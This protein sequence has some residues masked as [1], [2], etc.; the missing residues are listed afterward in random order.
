MVLPV[1]AFWVALA[2]MLIGVIGVILPGVPGVGLIWLAALVYAV[3]EGFATIDP[4]T[5]GLL[6]V[7]AVVGITADIWVSQVGGKLGGAS[8]KAL[9]ASLGLGTAGFLLG[10]LLGGVWSIPGGI[11][12]ALAGLILVQVRHSEDWKEA[13]RAGA[14][15]AVGCLL[16]GLVQL[17][18]SLAMIILFVWQV[19]R[20]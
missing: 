8:W 10:L 13:A 12:G 17:F 14:G 20:G 3:A 9:L 16:S 19:W 5:F 4:I 15:W 2:V 1:W 11:V 7:L 6:T 18:I